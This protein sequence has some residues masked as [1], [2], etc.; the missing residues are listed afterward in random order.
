MDTIE[1]DPNFGRNMCDTPIPGLP[2]N[3]VMSNDS[4]VGAGDCGGNPTLQT[5]EYGDTTG[6]LINLDDDSSPLSAIGNCYHN[7]NCD[8]CVNTGIQPSQAAITCFI[9]RQEGRL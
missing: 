9:G 8:T 5:W 1:S 7:W 4:A 3:I 6:A 2:D